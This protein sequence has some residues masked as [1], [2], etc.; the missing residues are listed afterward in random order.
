MTPR[1][2]SILLT[3][4]VLLLCI[5][6][7]ESIFPVI[8]LSSLILVV[9]IPPARRILLLTALGCA[10]WAAPGQH[11]AVPGIV[12]EEGEVVSIGCTVREAPVRMDYLTGSIQAD[13]IE[14]SRNC[15]CSSSAD[16]T[17]MLYVDWRDLPSGLSKGWMMRLPARY[18]NGRWYPAGD[19]AFEPP[20]GTLVSSF[21]EWRR[22]M[23]DRLLEGITD[24]P[25][26]AQQLAGALI[27]GIPIQRWG[28]LFELSRK[29]GTAH[30]M[31]LSGLHA[32]VIA[33]MAVL[34]L[35]PLTG[36]RFSR[37]GAMVLLVL[38][39]LIVGPRESLIRS[40]LMFWLYT[41][42][43]HR[44]LDLLS[45]S[46]LVQLIIRPGDAS[47]L[48]FLLSYS[49]LG[50]IL[51]GTSHCSDYLPWQIPPMMR[52]ML[53]MNICAF[54]SAAPVLM[55]HGLPVRT[56][57]LIVSIPSILLVTL[58]IWGTLCFLLGASERV[59]PV[60]LQEC[61]LLLERLWTW[62]AELPDGSAGV[63][64]IGAGVLT[65]LLILQ[66]RSR[67]SSHGETVSREPLQFPRFDQGST[68]D[69]GAS[70][71][72]AVR[73]EFSHQ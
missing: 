55:V 53:A 46:A 73:S 10:C 58:Y 65:I 12:L 57:G 48:G 33:S 4:P 67:R 41:M 39:L 32:G 45:L 34:V 16:G 49:A 28:G 63:P 69:A 23:Q 44:G 26:E 11:E 20:E 18:I 24:L 42:T 7:P 38:F 30:V 6:K 1:N 21:Q 60:L 27:L 14:V 50:G 29:S 25:W 17:V 2:L 66:Y 47:S 15:G 40:V 64:L 35:R 36:R 68:E 52:S 62:G 59:L 5:V 51:A 37:W 56:G 9:P 70:C 22:S 54:F 3:I 13:L 43:R 31:A 72:Q 19:V 61:A 71:D 8:G